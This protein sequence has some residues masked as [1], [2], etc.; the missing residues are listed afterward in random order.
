V[1][2]RGERIAKQHAT[3]GSMQPG[4]HK[5]RATPCGQLVASSIDVRV[6]ICDM[7]ALLLLLP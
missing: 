3:Q 4:Q 5:L 1:R 7:L 6:D 2:G